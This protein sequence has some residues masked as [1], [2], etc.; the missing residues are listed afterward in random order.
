MTEPS[1]QEPASLFRDAWHVYRD[2]VEHNYL[3]HRELGAC[4]GQVVQGR[5]GSRPLSVLDLGCGDASQTLRALQRVRIDSYHGCDLSEAA[6][7]QARLNLQNEVERPVLECPDMLA[8]MANAHEAFDLVFTSFAAH[9][10]ART[11]KG[12]FFCEARRLLESGG[13]LAL[14]DVVR[15]RGDDRARYLDAYMDHARVHWR[16]LNARD[17]QLVEDHVRAHDFPETLDTLAGLATEAGFT[18]IRPLDRHTWHA[19]MAFSS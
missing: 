11:D 6:L 16:A 3:F 1:T 8:T 14:I 15:D 18:Q 2:V 7:A 9:H 12:R 13:L 4:V 5:F 19:A 10:L 17:F